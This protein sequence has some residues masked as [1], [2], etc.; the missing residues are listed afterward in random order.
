MIQMD[1]KII[2][3]SIS[4]EE[5]KTM[6]RKFYGH[7]IKGVVDIEKEVIVF[8]GEYHMDANLVILDA[9]S[10]QNDV[11]G[12]NVVFDE[13]RDNWIEY[14]SLINIRPLVGNK[15]ME[16][17]DEKIKEKMKQIINSKIL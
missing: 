14:I 9:G 2:K 17:E 10:K 6:A 8:G 11:W 1:I 5:L 3:D 4:I 13:P 16:V 15:R 12:F 7:M